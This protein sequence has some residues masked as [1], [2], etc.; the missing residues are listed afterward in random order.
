[1][2]F[3]ELLKP[4][5][6]ARRR[7]ETESRFVPSDEDPEERVARVRAAVQRLSKFNIKSQID[8]VREVRGE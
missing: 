6:Q 4:E 1:M 7:A 2:T 3:E 5:E 8:F